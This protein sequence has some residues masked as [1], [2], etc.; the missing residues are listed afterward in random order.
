M[1][2]ES[3]LVYIPISSQIR[4]L[5]PFQ[6][7]IADLYLQDKLHIAL[8]ELTLDYKEGLFKLEQITTFPYEKPDS[9]WISVTVERN[10]AKK[11][12]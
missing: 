4:Q 11:E 9:V 2:K 12:F 7:N 1:V 8:D 5:I 3:T 10:L 6:V